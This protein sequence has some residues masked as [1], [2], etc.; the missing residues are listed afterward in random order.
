MQ[1][2]CK[3]WFMMFFK[4]LLCLFTVNA[5]AIVPKRV[6]LSISEESFHFARQQDLFL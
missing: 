2:Y 1:I 5:N 6:I 4:K 3:L